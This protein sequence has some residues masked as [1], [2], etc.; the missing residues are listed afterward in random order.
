MLSRYLQGSELSE[1][2]LKNRFQVAFNGVIYVRVWISVGA[3]I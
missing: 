1:Y 2:Q 3:N